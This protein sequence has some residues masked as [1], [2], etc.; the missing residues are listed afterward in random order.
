M[1]ATRRPTDEIGFLDGGIPI[2]TFSASTVV[3]SGNTFDLQRFRRYV[4]TAQC[5]GALSGAKTLALY[6]CSTSVSS[7]SSVSSN[8]TQ[9]DSASCVVSV[10]S[11][12]TSSTGQTLLV[13]DVR[14]EK[15]F[16]GTS[17]IRY[18][19]PVISTG[20]GVASNAVDSVSLIVQGFLPQYGP[21]SAAV[22]AASGFGAPVLTVETDYL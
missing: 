13:L 8:W 1:F 16:S 20:S 7:L 4:F 21:A 22:T 18:V 19:R 11:A 5:K 9:I 6:S 3:S 12:S 15:L 17:P 10:A 14:A 2:A